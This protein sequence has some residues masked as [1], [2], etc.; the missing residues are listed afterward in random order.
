MSLDLTILQ[1]PL[2]VTES[3]SDH[4]W[5]IALNDYSA[6]TDI[7]LVVD[8]YKNPYQNDIGP[9]NAQGTNQQYGK[10]GRLLV[11]VNE[12]GNC[13][14]NVETIIRN[15]VQGNPRNMDM[16]MT[17][18]AGTAQ[19]NPYLV[20]YYD[21]NGLNYTANTSQATIVNERPSTV[22]FSNGFNG[23][24]EG[25]DNIYH[26]NEY[27]LIFGVQY[28]SG[29]TTQL[30]IDNTNYNVYSGWTGQTISPY[31]AA[32]QPYGVMIWPGVQDNKRF[33]VST[34]PNIELYYSGTNLSGKY[35]YWNTKVFNFGMNTGVAPYNVPGEFMGTFGTQTIPMTAFGGSPIQTRW[36]THYYK[37]PIVLGFMYGA[38][39]L[40]DNSSVVNSISF[41]QKTQTNNQMNYDVVQSVPVNYTTKPFGQY[42]W[43]GQRIAYAIWKQNPLVRTQ[44]DVAVFLSEG[45]CD[46]TI[47]SGVS[48]VV[49]Y[50]M[51]GEECFNDPVN[52]LF[53]NRNGVW[54]TYTFTKKYS[55]KYNMDKKVYSQY[56]SLNTT[57]WNRQSYDSQETVFWGN[58]D[59]IVT[60]D[61]NF[62]QQNDAVIIEELLMSPY[63]YMIMDNWI[64][65]EPFEKNY[66]YLIPCTVQNKTVEVYIQ[67]YERIFQYTIDLKQTP[68]RR[69][70]LP[71]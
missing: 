60:V 27:R 53:M 5:N 24:Y 22:G 21:N 9:N 30:I 32:T 29:G 28:T 48:E 3:H 54:D 43:L 8:V 4:T 63:V 35:N 39:A 70:E 19:N 67:K 46:P 55:K 10:F 59:E 57:V 58:A 31:S 61:S 44:S 62:V 20:E 49:Q 34:N 15:F 7:R 64:P 38:N 36:R 47:T 12:Y 18:T 16:I 66:P 56:K 65:E 26:I 51:V 11:P 52:F 17:L 14:F 6:Y 37:C 50:K 2:D 40:Y 13:I 68:Y 71:I 45:D 33:G 69:F 42:S 25:F 1:K 23:G 41:L